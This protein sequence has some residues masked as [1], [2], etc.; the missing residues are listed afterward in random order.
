MNV[1]E[2][3]QQLADAKRAEAAARDRRV[4]VE[5]AI[6][7]ELACERDRSKTHKLDGWKVTL[8]RPVNRRLDVKAW[9][10]IKGDIPEELRPVEYKPA[11]NASG[12]KWL[13]ENDPE[14][15]AKCAEAITETEGKVSVT[16]ARLED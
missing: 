8:K 4:E 15:W 5:L 3:C 14:T 7:A 12:C 9:D 2:M 13:A 11:I 1:E 10:R 6:A 16:V